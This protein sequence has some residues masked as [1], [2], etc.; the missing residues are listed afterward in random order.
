MLVFLFLTVLEVSSSGYSRAVETTVFDDFESYATGTFPH[1]GGWELWFSGAGSQFQII[2]D[3]VS[4]SPTKSL[5]L[6]G[7]WGWAAFAAK[8]FSSSSSQI[9]FEV[10]VRVEE[11]TGG[12]GDNARISFTK[13]LS[14]S[15]SREYAPILFLDSGVIACGSKYLQSYAPRT[16]Y[17]VK[18]MLDRS[19]DTCSVWIDDQLRAQDLPMPTTSPPDTTRPSYEI[20]A[21]S[22]SQCYNGI[23]AFFDD[24]KLFGVEESVSRVPGVHAEDWAKYDVVFNYTTDDSNPPMPPPPPEYQDIDYYKIRVIAVVGTNITFEISARFRNGTEISNIS[25][26]DVSPS[27]SMMFPPPFIAANLS[28]GDRIYSSPYSVTINATVMRTYAGAE[29]EVVCLEMTQDIDYIPGYRTTME[30][31]VYWDRASGIVDE[32]IQSERMTKIP[33]GYETRFYGHMIMRETNIW[34]PAHATARLFIFPRTLNLESEGKWVTAWVLLPAG[35]DARE[36]DASTI[37]LN[38]TVP[39]A[40]HIAV[41]IRLL[42]VKFDRNQ[43]ASYILENVKTKEEL[44]TV[45]LTVNGKF[46]DGTAFQ[47]SDNIRAIIPREHETLNPNKLPRSFSFGF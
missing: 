15:I 14:S 47:G 2:V 18:L 22:V 20:E 40:R 5:Q 28:A 26:I 27:Y 29:R 23:R 24:V 25:W 8:R 38:D 46:E 3:S 37:R 33:E 12:I 1:S 16:W 31:K 19:T 44:V 43:V 34:K 4:V 42:I 9:G 41:G 32:M 13:L 30:L 10:C 6:L 17:R 36:I 7:I 35:Y 11:V 21:F 39:Q 45:V